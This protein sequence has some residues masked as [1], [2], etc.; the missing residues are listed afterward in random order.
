MEIT[1]ESISQIF[2][3]SKRYW[4]IYL[5][6]IA[7]TCLSTLSAKNFVKPE[8]VITTF[9]IVAVLG[10]ICIVYYFMHDSENELYKVAFVII[11]CFGMMSSLIVPIVDVSDELEHLTRAEITSQGVIFPHW[12]SGPNNLNR[13]Y[14]HT[15]EGKYSTALNK[16]VGFRTSESHMFFLNNR[17]NTVFDTPGDTDKISNSTI[18]DGSAFEQNPFYGYLPQ[19]I[20]VFLAKLFDMNVIWMLWLGRIFNLISYAFLISLAIKKAPVLK[21]PLLAVACI[22]LSIYQAAS[23][24]IDSMV[25]GLGILTIAYF[26]YLYKASPQSLDTKHVALF[27]GLSLLLGLC[28]LPYLAFVFLILLVP[29]ENF[30]DKN[31]LRY[32][33]LGILIVAF[34]GVL[35][36]TYSE[37]ALMHS[38]RSKLNYMNPALQAEYLIN[39]PLA[40]LNFLRLIFT[41][42]LGI[43]VNG[44]FNFFAAGSAYHYS[45]HY[46]LITVFLWIFLAFTLLFYPN[47]SKFNSK[48]RLGSLLIL[49]MVYVG[50]CFIQLLTWADVGNTNIGVST[51]YFLPLF[52]LL[53]IIVP[54]SIRKLDEFKESYDKYAMIFIIGFMATLILAFATKYYL[55]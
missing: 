9:L 30:K 55:I 29:K 8:F 4:L 13:L 42:T 10:I 15:S 21:I 51:R 16:D 47:K 18:L 25:I 7:I 41:Q 52:A 11:L 36:S 12:E 17:E 45:D 2:I 50:T 24:S 5:I 20:G 40:I 53:P 48:A 1:L 3:K 33:L 37:P 27:C 35:W 6:F 43:T 19:A 32:M 46:T 23:V 44:L 28:K 22:P 54:F 34:A 31:I 49:L 39:N 38:W 26:L 14:N